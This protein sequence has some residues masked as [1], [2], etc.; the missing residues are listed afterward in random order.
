MHH[1]QNL[2][3]RSDHQRLWYGE[4]HE[5]GQPMMHRNRKNQSA[6]VQDANKPSPQGKDSY[7]RYIAFIRVMGHKRPFHI[8]T[9]HV[10]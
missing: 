5:K 10:T 7:N 8:T 2:F 9:M 3:H 6:K 4:K 1:R